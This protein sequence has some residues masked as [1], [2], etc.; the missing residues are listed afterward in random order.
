MSASL[1]ELQLK[2]VRELIAA[3]RL[4]LTSPV[5]VRKVHSR[6]AGAPRALFLSMQRDLNRPMT[7]A[8]FF[9]N[10]KTT[11]E[12]IIGLEQRALRLEREVALEPVLKLTA[13]VTQAAEAFAKVG[14]AFEDVA[15][16]AVHYF[17]SA[18]TE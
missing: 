7:R 14:K 12:E 6:P 11:F 2:L 3:K 13:D 8:E 17:S 16:A 18:R 4:E 10:R 9:Q 1:T 15:T 5:P